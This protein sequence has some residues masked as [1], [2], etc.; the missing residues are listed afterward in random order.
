V[1]RSRGCFFRVT[2]RF[3]RSTSACT[4]VP[5]TMYPT[6]VFPSRSIGA[7]RILLHANSATPR[8]SLAATQ[9]EGVNARF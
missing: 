8:V 1:S 5:R 4:I 9:P 6:L 2:L 3:T 7:T